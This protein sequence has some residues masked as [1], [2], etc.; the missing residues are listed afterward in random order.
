MFEGRKVYST[1]PPEL[2]WDV[3]AF[4]GSYRKAREEGRAL[5]MGIAD[6]T[7]IHNACVMAAVA[8]VGWLDMDHSLSFH[9]SLL[10]KLPSLL[11][12]YIAC[13]SYIYGDVET[14]DIIRVHIQS[15]KLTL[16]LCEEFETS[17]LPRVKER[18]KIS[19]RHQSIDFFSSSDPGV[20]PYLYLK[21][22]LIPQDYPRYKDQ[23]RFDA[24]LKKIVQ[25]DFSGHGPRTKDFEDALHQLGLQVKGFQLQKKGRSRGSGS[26]NDE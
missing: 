5:L 1:L 15:G 16:L 26:A 19:I 8:G 22:R 24:K 12:V 25:L 9:A 14:A 4:F 23:S 17:P 6:T 7:L 3:A 21:S 13:G 10:H 20:R 2:R 18:V 11:R